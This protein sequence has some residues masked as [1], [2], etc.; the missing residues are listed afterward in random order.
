MRARVNY[1]VRVLTPVLLVCLFAPTS[2]AYAAPPAAT[3]KASPQVQAAPTSLPKVPL[4]QVTS[5]PGN[6]TITVTDETGPVSGAPVNVTVKGVVQTVQTNAAGQAQFANL[7]MGYYTFM[8]DATSPRTAGT[9]SVTLL[10]GGTATGTIAVKRRTGSATI[11]VYYYPD[12]YQACWEPSPTMYKQV[13]PGATVSVTGGG[14]SRSATTGADGVVKIDTLL[15]GSYTFSASKTGFSSVS[16]ISTNVTVTAD[17]AASGSVPLAIVGNSVI[18]TVTDGNAP[19]DQ[20]WVSIYCPN[21]SRTQYLTRPTDATGKATFLNVEPG[22]H[23][24]DA[25]KLGYWRG[26]PSSISLTVDTGTKTGNLVLKKNGSAVVTV[27]DENAQPLTGVTVSSL[28]LDI[29]KTDAIGRA[30]F[31]NAAPGPHSFTASM[32]GY[33]DGTIALTIPSGGTVSGSITLKRR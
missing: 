4:G 19:L 11:Q 33:S 15:P 8:V 12:K 21:N 13:I 9:T 29:K 26:S 28:Y 20:V 32:I 1:V 2:T 27:I 22:T 31:D 10:S 17:Q 25:Q 23:V 30:T 24:F 3:Q 18:I 14:A 16:G 7:E 5:V 6:A